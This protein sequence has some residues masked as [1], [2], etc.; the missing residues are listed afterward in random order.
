[1]ER[2]GRSE[3]PARLDELLM[4]YLLED[5]RGRGR[6]ENIYERALLIDNDVCIEVDTRDTILL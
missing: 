1:M 4:R 2:G 5:V 6:E 3:R